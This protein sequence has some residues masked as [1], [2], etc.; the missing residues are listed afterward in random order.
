MKTLDTRK[1]FRK[2]LKNNYSLKAVGAKKS[3]ITTKK[4]KNRI[5]K[6][7]KQKEHIEKGGT[8][9]IVNAIK[10]IRKEVLEMRKK[11]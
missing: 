7:L 9:K 3:T 4:E 2:I 5:S 1:C 11:M 8:K 6:L 10:N